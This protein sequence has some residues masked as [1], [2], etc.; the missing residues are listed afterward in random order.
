MYSNI[1]TQD[2]I[3]N[4]ILQLLIYRQ[5]RLHQVLL[6]QSP[7]CS[8]IQ[9]TSIFFLRIE[10]SIFIVQILLEL[11]L[12][13]IQHYFLNLQRLKPLMILFN[14]SLNY[15]IQLAISKQQIQYSLMVTRLI[16]I[17][18]NHSIISYFVILLII[19]IHNRIRE[20][21]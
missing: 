10:I 4:D 19:G 11:N 2:A 8:I 7:L 14:H 18:Q 5:Q 9:L 20:K 6:N 16:L 21:F 13:I 1:S 3:Q 17:L 15:Q 12:I